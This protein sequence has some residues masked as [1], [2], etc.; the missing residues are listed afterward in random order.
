M[1]SPRK[2]CTKHI[3]SKLKNSPQKL[4]EGVYNQLF[5]SKVSCTFHVD[6]RDTFYQPGGMI[7]CVCVFRSLFCVTVAPMT[8]LFNDAGR[9][10]HV[11]GINLYSRECNMSAT[12]DA[13][14]PF[15]TILQWQH[16]RFDGTVSTTG[17]FTQPPSQK[18]Y[19]ET[20]DPQSMIYS[21][22]FIVLLL[23]FCF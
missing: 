12:I 8:C 20:I 11:A 22:K 1:C 23:F 13:S 17:L 18:I 19:T 10:K 4:A 21:L 7:V 15:E 9:P 2:R 5:L 6:T 3:F 14:N 16:T